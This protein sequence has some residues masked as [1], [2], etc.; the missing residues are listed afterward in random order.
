MAGSLVPD[1]V[2]SGCRSVHVTELIRR[3]HAI[4]TSRDLC[5]RANEGEKQL[6][7]YR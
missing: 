5:S 2:A 7:A 3:I 6:D 1:L 4:N